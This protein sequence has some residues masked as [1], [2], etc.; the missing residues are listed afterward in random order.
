MDTGSLGA[1]AFGES[2]G[3]RVNSSQELIRGLTGIDGPYS[4]V[5]NGDRSGDHA[6]Y[7]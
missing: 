1:A 5:P 4:D 2:S 6:R 3:E 7:R